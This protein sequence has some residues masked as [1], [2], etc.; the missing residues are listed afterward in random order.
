MGAA[1]VE[2]DRQTSTPVV[3][4]CVDA[5]TE[6]AERLRVARPEK[7]KQPVVRWRRP[8]AT[9]RQRHP[10]PPGGQR[11]DFDDAPQ[12]GQNFAV[13]KSGRGLH[14]LNDVWPDLAPR[15]RARLMPARDMA[16]ALATAGAP[17]GA[18]EIGV[19]RDYL[20]TTIL[21]ARFLRSRY[22]LLDLLDETGLLPQAAEAGLGPKVSP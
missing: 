8:I 12:I 19:A 10:R 9:T 4:G 18:A 13:R 5:A 15:L 16:R 3:A 2:R 22:T 17:S 20:H 7:G 11:F 14:R 6:L 1:D 21:K